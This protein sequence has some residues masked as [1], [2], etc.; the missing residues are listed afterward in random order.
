[1]E[2]D[3]EKKL[4][5]LAQPLRFTSM[6]PRPVKILENGNKTVDESIQVIFKAEL[7]A[8]A[9]KD[10]TNFAGQ[11]SLTNASEFKCPASSTTIVLLGDNL[12]VPYPLKGYCLILK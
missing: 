7:L 10:P 2:V 3:Y 9:K 1:M 11:L 4:A 5:N 6:G 12:H 8:E